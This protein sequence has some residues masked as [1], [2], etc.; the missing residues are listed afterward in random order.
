MPNPSSS[1]GSPA[2]A[3]ML[4]SEDAIKTETSTEAATLVVGL[5]EIGGPLLEI[6]REVHHA[7]GRDIEDRPYDGVQVL[8]LCFPYTSD[9]VSSASRYVSLYEPGVVVVN[10]T[11]VP[12]TTREIQEKTGVLAVY[13]PVRGKHARMTD[14]LGRYR[15]FVA[16]TS[17]HAVALVEDHFAAVGMTTQRMSSPEALELAKLLETTYFGVLV[18]WAQEMDRFAEAVDADYWETIDFFAEIDFFPP[19]GFQP[20]YIGGHCVMPNLELLEQLRRSPFIDV[21]RESNRRRAREWQ[22]RGLST[23]D[24]LSP[25]TARRQA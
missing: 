15:K 17:V 16:G 14:E 11:V 1:P 12:G 20:G 18:A 25:R 5:G 9:F 23:A 7:A 19:V 10:S 24:R 22:E 13:S 3:G 8:H 4:S 6:L 2:A 21:M